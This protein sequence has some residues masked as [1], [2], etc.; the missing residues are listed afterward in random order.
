[1]RRGLGTTPWCLGAV[2]FWL[3]ACTPAP[4]PPPPPVAWARPMS[5]DL[6]TSLLE[7]SDDVRFL[8]SMSEPCIERRREAF[9]S[10]I[11]GQVEK[12]QVIDAGHA[13]LRDRHAWVLQR[14]GRHREALLEY[15]HLIDLTGGE[16]SIWVSAWVGAATSQAAMGRLDDAT[17][18]L[19][20]ARESLASLSK[21]PWSDDRLELAVERIGRIWTWLGFVVDWDEFGLSPSTLP[22]GD[23]DWESAIMDRFRNIEDRIEAWLDLHELR[24]AGTPGHDPAG[25]IP[26]LRSILESHPDHR[27]TRLDLAIAFLE[28]DR[29]D[30][31]RVIL[32]AMAD[33]DDD[34]AHAG[35][36]VARIRAALETASMLAESSPQ[37]ALDRLVEGE[38]LLEVYIDAFPGWRSLEVTPPDLQARTT[39]L[40]QGMAFAVRGRIRGSVEIPDGRTPQIDL[41]GAQALI[42]P[43][44]DAVD[45]ASGAPVECVDAGLMERVQ[46]EVDRLRTM[47]AEERGLT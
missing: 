35:L 42:E 36:Q 28:S 18:S 47:L 19:A 24:I 45:Q 15:E 44:E 1:M 6:R 12:L 16:D 46:E 41:V 21:Y 27:P 23:G 39:R 31:A 25:G 13:F 38:R 8:E 20:A 30:D 40:L 22:N 9:E 37:R 17:S 5:A 3:T 11:L 32:D 10:G 2:A 14:A 7:V 29:P 34:P 43:V 26:Q 33:V 4:V